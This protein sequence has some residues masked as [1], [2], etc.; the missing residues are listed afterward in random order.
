MRLSTGRP[1]PA[2]ASTSTF[3]RPGEPLARRLVVHP[4]AVSAAAVLAAA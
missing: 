3:C 2:L 1:G 4:G